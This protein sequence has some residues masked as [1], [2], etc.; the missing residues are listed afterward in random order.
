MES[1]CLGGEPG[2]LVLERKKAGGL[3]PLDV[4]GRIFLLAGM[5]AACPLPL[6]GW[7]MKGTHGNPS[8]SAFFLGL[9][10]AAA[11][12]KR[13]QCQ[14]GGDPASRK[15]HITPLKGSEFQRRAHGKGRRDH[16]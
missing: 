11:P 10:L 5:L 2:D 16:E 4:P 14:H 3:H 7:S 12:I 13:S 9:F 15:L 8:P 6:M 1:I